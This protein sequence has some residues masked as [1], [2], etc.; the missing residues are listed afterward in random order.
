MIEKAV[1]KKARLCRRWK[2]GRR[3]LGLPETNPA[4]GFLLDR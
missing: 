4:G 1:I 2:N 3:E